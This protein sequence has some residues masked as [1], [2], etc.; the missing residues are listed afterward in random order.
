MYSALVSNRIHPAMTKL[1]IVNVVATANLEQQVDLLKMASLENVM[2]N[3]DTY[4]G[5]VAYLKKPNMHGKVSVF[6]TGRMISTGT[7]HPEQANEDLNNAA[8]FLADN[9]LVDV[10][11]TKTVTRNIVA[12]LEMPGPLSLEEAARN[13]NAIYEPDQ[14]PGAIVKQRDPKAT[15]LLFS[16]AKIVI[17]GTRSLEEL[18]QALEHIQSLLGRYVAPIDG[19]CH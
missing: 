12:L 19:S 16:S 4:G 11:T 17:L 3:I 18:N 8:A 9:R 1:R 10:T 14:F 2:Y 6:T 15:Y 5:R 13:L 7:T